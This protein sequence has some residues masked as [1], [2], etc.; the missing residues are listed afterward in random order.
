MQTD[1]EIAQLAK[2]RKRS[3]IAK[4]RLEIPED[5]LEAF[6]R[7][8]AKVSLSYLCYNNVIC[9]ILERQIGHD[10]D[11]RFGLAVWH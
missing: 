4:T 5:E 6:G 2:M 7:F 10:H 9:Y 3:D 8:K 1:I 11:D